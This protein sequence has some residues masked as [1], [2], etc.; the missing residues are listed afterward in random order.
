[1]RRS[2]VSPLN[3]VAD[4][5]PDADKDRILLLFCES[6]DRYRLRYQCG[7]NFVPSHPSCSMLPWIGEQEDKEL[8]GSLL[9]LF[10][11]MRIGLDDVVDDDVFSFIFSRKR[12]A[13]LHALREH[14]QGAGC[15]GVCYGGCG[16]SPKPWV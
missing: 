5:G 10:V 11:G 7:W 8:S 14:P 6:R 12:S 16:V 3:V 4:D 1:M 9:E 15:C 2:S 13:G